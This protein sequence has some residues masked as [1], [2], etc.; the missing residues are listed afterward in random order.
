M[1][2]ETI[3]KTVS[4]IGSGNVAH[5]LGGGL[6]KAG[7]KIEAVYS[8][9]AIKARELAIA[10]NSIPVDHPEALPLNSDLYL[11][12]V[13]DNAIKE[14]CGMMAD[15]KGLVAHSSGTAGLAMLTRFSRSGV[16]Y[17]LQTLSGGLEIPF[18]QI[19]FLIEANN[20]T[21]EASL[22]EIAHLLG[23]ETWHV[24]SQQRQKIHLAAV[25]VN[26][27]SNYLYRIAEQL[28]KED[29]LPLEM[30]KPLII[31]TANK[32]N[33]ASP[34]LMQTGPA[35]RGDSETSAKHIELLRSFPEYQKLYEMMSG[36]I[37][38]SEL[39]KS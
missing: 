17:P 39:K 8:R 9:N 21:D 11:I 3:L 1:H 22:M 16:F 15:V 4:I 25:F 20:H 34:Q 38:S 30:L 24:N 13:S 37:L 19:P 28:M 27:F 7:L 23:S 29:G 2:T 6:H 26:N 12:M 18:S 35:K 10:L 36:M 33:R 5:I 32:I 14:V 31:Q